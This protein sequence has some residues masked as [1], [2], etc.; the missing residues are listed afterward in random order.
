MCSFSALLL[1]ELDTLGGIY[2]KRYLDKTLILDCAL[3]CILCMFSPVSG[4]R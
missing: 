1:G 3:I 2:P 4:T